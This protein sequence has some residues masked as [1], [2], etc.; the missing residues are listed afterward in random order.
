[1]TLSCEDEL[2]RF[3]RARGIEDRVKFTGYVRNVH[4]YLQAADLFVFPTEGEAFPLSLVEAMSCGLP[5]I[6]SRVGGIPEIV[7]HGRDGIL[8][9]PANPEAL[10]REIAFLMKETP[11]AGSLGSNARRTVCEAYSIESVA[12]QYFESL[13]G[14]CAVRGGPRT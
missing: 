1:M 4:E 14:I 10:A 12:S 9:D 2:R 8:V 6:A 5:V 11:T 13:C 3:V 7:T